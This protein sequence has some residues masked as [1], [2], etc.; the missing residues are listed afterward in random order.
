LLGARLRECAAAVLEHLGDTSAEAI[1]GPVDAMKLRSSMLI[2]AEAVPDEPL[3]D[4][5]RRMAG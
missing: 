2:F 1:L 4:E 5:V 3:F